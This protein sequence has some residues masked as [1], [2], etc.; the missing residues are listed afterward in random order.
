MAG[1]NTDCL[2]M[3]FPIVIATLPFR[4][5]AA[6]LPLLHYGSHLSLRQRLELLLSTVQLEL[7][8]L[9]ENAITTVEGGNYISPEFQL[10]QVY[11]GST[12]NGENDVIVFYRPVYIC[13]KLSDDEASV[14]LEKKASSTDTYHKEE[15]PETSRSRT[16]SKDA[17]AASTSHTLP[18]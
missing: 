11:D 5:P 15:S 7:L 6:A 13:V 16:A 1:R 10:G 14:A 12:E 3:E 17:N 4:I 18:I 8:F 2:H 9:S